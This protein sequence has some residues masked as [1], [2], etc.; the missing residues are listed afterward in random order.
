MPVMYCAV[1]RFDPTWADS[2]SK[3]IDW[4]GLTQLREVISLD[5]ILCPSIFQ[6]LTDEDWQHNVRE[7]FKTSYF[8]DLDY[9]LGKLAGRDRANV[10]AV[11]HEPPPAELMSFTDHRFVFRGFDLIEQ[12]GNISALVNCGGFP[13]AFFS[14]ELSDCG[15]LA[16]QAVASSIQR[17]LQAEYPDDHHAECDVWAIWQLK[18]AS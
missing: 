5:G 4:S 14:T 6:E 17:K 10:L 8:H 7:D 16:D 3:F 11:M 2:W 12:G 13:K 15:L 1:E 9:V 18:L